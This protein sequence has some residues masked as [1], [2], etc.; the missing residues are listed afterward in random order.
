MPSAFLFQ[1]HDDIRKSFRLR[2][3]QAVLAVMSKCANEEMELTDQLWKVMRDA[4]IVRSRDKM[5]EV[6]VV[7][8]KALVYF[9]PRL[10]EEE[11]EDDEEDSDNE[12]QP[13]KLE[14]DPVVKR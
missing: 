2:V 7:A 1:F 13:R 3:C 14:N 10:G 5:F 9:Q 6:R 4:L 12:G 11:C 8:V